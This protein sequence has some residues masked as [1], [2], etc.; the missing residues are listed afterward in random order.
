MEKGR[1]ACALSGNMHARSLHS[2][3][4]IFS[5]YSWVARKDDDDDETFDQNWPCLR[6]LCYNLIV[7]EN[8]QNFQ[9]ELYQHYP[10][11]NAN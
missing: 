4:C 11:T 2:G 7:I 5:V 8:D 3:D 9:K 10:V 1:S 6:S